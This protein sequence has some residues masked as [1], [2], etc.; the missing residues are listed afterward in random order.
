MV[1]NVLGKCTHEGCERNHTKQITATQAT[2]VYQ[3]ILPGIQ[4]L[5]RPAGR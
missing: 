2:A 5:L 3:L 1:F 4:N